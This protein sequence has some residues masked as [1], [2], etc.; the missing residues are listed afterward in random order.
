MRTPLSLATGIAAIAAL[1]LPAA[2]SASYGG[3]VLANSPVAFYE[4][5]ETAGTTAANSGTSGAAGNGTYSNS[6]V[7]LGATAPF[8]DAGTAV[9]LSGSGSVSA[10]LPAGSTVRTIELWVR[11]SV[12][13][14]Q[15]F[16]SYAGQWS[17]GIAP[18]G[19]QGIT[20]SS[21]RKL[22][23]TDAAGKVVNSKIVL[24]S[25]AWSMVDVALDAAAN[26]VSFYLNGGA[27]SKSVPAP[28][29]FA[30]PATPASATALTIGPGAGK[31][32][33][34][35]DEVALYPAVLKLSDVKAHFSA[36]PLPDLATAP[37]LS[38]L[39]GIK[40]GDTLAFT[41]GTYTSGTAV[42][43]SDTWY[44]CN[45]A[46]TD[47]SVSPCAAIATVSGGNSTYKLQ[48]ADLGF[49][50]MVE[51]TATNAAGSLVTDTA[52]T[53][54]VGNVPT[55][56]TNPPPA[57][58]NGNPPVVTPAGGTPPAGGTTSGGGTTTGVSGSSNSC[59]ARF[60]A[61]K[62]VTARLGRRS[63]RLSFAPRTRLV[64]LAAPRHTVKTVTY[65]LDGRRVR[66]AKAAPYRLVVSLKGLR[67]GRHT[68]KAVVKLRTGK[69]RTLAL[70]LDLK[71]C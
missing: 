20:P 35:V 19:G 8:S 24:P 23:L 26:Q 17:L 28:A 67:T 43:L 14:A 7:T 30:F 45:D 40:V 11:P 63:L 65:R 6:G 55:T 54:P 25:G 42:T 44:R 13:T 71:G 1:A 48:Q 69:A 56:S 49:T 68:L 34:T 27:V 58:D 50:I 70:R 46:V 29:G 4:L 64:K 62:A 21:K 57:G 37:A 38:P 47:P 66:V 51:E 32:G 53:D 15:T 61:V 60:A 18:N 36:S 41:Q 2:A 31:S 12:R 22:I 59:V 33:T 3:A 39:T 9:T 10:A 52:E 16:V 5:N